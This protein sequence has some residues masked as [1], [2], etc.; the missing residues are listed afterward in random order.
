MACKSLLGR[1][2]LAR[3]L[4]QR[5]SIV[6]CTD[7]SFGPMDRTVRLGLLR[8]ASLR[9]ATMRK[10]MYGIIRDAICAGYQALALLRLSQAT[11][12]LPKKVNWHYRTSKMSYVTWKSS[13]T[14]SV[15]AWS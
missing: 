12:D 5:V 13:R 7:E 14:I 6:K 2:R 9:A 11:V 4:P 8:G 3:R 10:G 15:L 1:S